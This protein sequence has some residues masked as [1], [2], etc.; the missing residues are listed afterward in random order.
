M[1]EKSLEG[2]E[3]RKISSGEPIIEGTGDELE[4]S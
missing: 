2:K 4:E 1:G 3:L